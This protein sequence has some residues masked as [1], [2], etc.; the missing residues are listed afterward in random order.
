MI[1]SGDHGGMRY[2]LISIEMEKQA[3]RSKRRW[4][5][6]RAKRKENIW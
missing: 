1:E 4:R 6:Q 5:G 2:D 3:P